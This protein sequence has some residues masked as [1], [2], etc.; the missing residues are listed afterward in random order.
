MIYLSNISFFLVELF[1]V[2]F[3]FNSM[4]TNNWRPNPS[5]APNG[6]G[7]GPGAV[8]A[9]GGGEPTMD[10]G[11]WRTQLPLDSRQRIVNKM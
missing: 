2:E 8:G 5:Q 7:G 1:E 6:G 9:G 11:D 3:H 10:T 4:D